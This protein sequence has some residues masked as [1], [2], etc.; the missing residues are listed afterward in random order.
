[1]GTSYLMGAGTPPA[2]EVARRAQQSLVE[3]AGLQ[4]PEAEE[5]GLQVPEGEEAGLQVLPGGFHWHLRRC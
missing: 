2:E 4:V 5:A 3:E 1:M